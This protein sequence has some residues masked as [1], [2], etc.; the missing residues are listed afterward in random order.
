M[1][2]LSSLALLSICLL[3]VLSGTALGAPRAS[4]IADTVY[5]DGRI[6]TADAADHVREAIAIRAGRIVYAGSSAGA[7]SFIGPT[8]RVADLH[9]RFAMPGL[10][11]AH[12]HPLEGGS[13][14]LKCDLKYER[15]TVPQ[16]Q[17]HIQACLDADQGHEPDGW[18]EVTN[19]FLQGMLPADVT[20]SHATLD[21]LRTGRPILAHDSFGHTVLANGRALALAGIV[22]ASTDPSGGKIDR[23]ANGEP[24]GMLE[25]SAADPFD[26]LIPPASAAEDLAAARAALLAIAKQGV[27][28]ALDADAHPPALEAF[29]AIDRSGG[30]TARMHFAI[31]IDTTDIANPAAAV[32]RVLA[33]HRRFDHA[34]LEVTP[35][36]TVRNA[37]M[38][39]DGVISGPAFTGAMIEPYWVNAGTA[40]APRWQP[41]KDR[42]PAVY[43]PAPVLADILTRLARAGIDPHMHA[44]GDMGVRAALDAVAAMR[45]VVPHADI[46]PSIAHDE[47]V[48][49]ADYPRYKS[50]G[51]FP[52]LSFQWEKPA[53]DTVDQL[54]DYLG[55]ER[56]AI[57][58]PAGLL[59]GAGAPVAFGSDWPVDALNEWFA[60]KVAV[61][62]TNAPGSGYTGRLGADPGL[63]LLQTLR[64]AT[65]VSARALHQDRQTGSLEA[66]KFADLIVL[67]RD[68]TRIPPEDIA[69]VRVLETIVGGRT[70]YSAD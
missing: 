7:R 8:T 53:P 59:Q 49:R 2:R 42:G 16:F 64:A 61:T 14:L 32:E 6:Y 34:P 5:L 3:P 55:P 47:I 27:T 31:H 29:A 70:V 39:M 43:Y 44:D 58:E 38:Y 46:R 19:W 57:L 37:K 25:D 63:T 56:A 54:R 13:R 26:H 15:L 17:A 52:V 69:N 30:L 11:D 48:A 22:R 35:H 24:N 60:L 10:I 36:L 51:T 23:D 45:K 12:M 18:M 33:A 50:L 41:G 68:P 65:I 9:G 62:R 21:V 67:D 28:S 1:R 66:G 40:A 4:T 20:I